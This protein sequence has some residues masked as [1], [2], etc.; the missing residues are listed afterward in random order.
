MK[1]PKREQY[2]CE[3]VTDTKLK[4]T[5]QKP[6]HLSTV[7]NVYA[8]HTGRLHH[9]RDELD[10][11]YHKLNKLVGANKNHNLLYIA[12]NFN[13]KV[14]RA[15]G[16]T[17]IGRYSRGRTN[18]RGTALLEVCETNQLFI[19]FQQRA[20]HITTWESRRSVNGKLITF[21]NQVDYIACSMDMKR[22]LTNA[23]SYSGTIT[24]TDHRLLVARFNI[25]KYKLYKTKSKFSHHLTSIACCPRRKRENKTKPN[26][27]HE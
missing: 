17:C 12:G 23:R 16:Y 21:F 1:L 20:S 9:N 14:G 24:D 10:E 15:T 11:V 6:K 2:R 27:R 3:R 4:L 18:N 13:A 26:W 8:P 7:V 25:R 5:T 19:S 22:N